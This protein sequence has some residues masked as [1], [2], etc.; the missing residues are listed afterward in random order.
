MA[1]NTPK[2][3]IFSADILS[4]IGSKEW[5]TSMSGHV[6]FWSAHFQGFCDRPPSKES[7]FPLFCSPN[8]G[9]RGEVPKEF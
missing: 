1:L 8:L 2:S 4:V 6:G 5:G 3:A 9:Y 7:H